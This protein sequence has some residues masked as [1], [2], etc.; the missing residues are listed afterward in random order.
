MGVSLRIDWGATPICPYRGESR[1]SKSCRP[2]SIGCARSGLYK[3]TQGAV[4]TANFHIPLAAKRRTVANE[5]Q[6][7]TEIR[8]EPANRGGRS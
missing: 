8:A 2:T 1:T 6:G 4:M 3:R 5:L 7:T